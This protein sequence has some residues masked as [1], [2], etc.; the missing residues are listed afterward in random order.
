MISYSSKDN[1]ANPQPLMAR[2]LHIIQRTTGLPYR[3]RRP[4]PE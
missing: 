4:S 2:E 3:R 1:L